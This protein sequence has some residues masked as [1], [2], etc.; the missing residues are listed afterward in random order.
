ALQAVLPGAPASAESAAAQP[1]A[2]AAHQDVAPQRA[3]LATSQP[4]PPVGA[5]EAVGPDAEALA[6]AALN[7]YREAKER[8]AAGD[9]AGYGA[10]VDGLGAVLRRLAGEP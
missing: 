6:A 3:G 1:S 2:E 10:A 4:R 8:L 7:L 5:A 9:W